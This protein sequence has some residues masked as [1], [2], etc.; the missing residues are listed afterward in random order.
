MKKKAI[1]LV[2]LLILKCVFVKNNYV[3]SQKLINKCSQAKGFF[4]CCFFFVKKTV[5][6]LKDEFYSKALFTILP[7][8]WEDFEGA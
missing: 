1:F 3:L 5:A 4:F 2:A 8:W 7:E 6:A